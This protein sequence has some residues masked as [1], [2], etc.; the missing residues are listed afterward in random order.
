MTIII[1]LLSQKTLSNPAGQKVLETLKTEKMWKNKKNYNFGVKNAQKS[2]VFLK[3]TFK[4][5]KIS[6]NVTFLFDRRAT[7][8][9]R[10]P[11]QCMNQ[12]RKDS[13]MAISEMN[14]YVNRESGVYF[15]SFLSFVVV[16][17]FNLKGLQKFH[18]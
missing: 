13:S 3:M 4:A 10:D 1:I 14:E 6:T 18:S 12:M 7:L 5:K 8:L 2:Y 15:V 17:K 9:A 11:C 16:K